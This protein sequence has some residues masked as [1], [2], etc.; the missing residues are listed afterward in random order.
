MPAVSVV[1]AH[2]A[3]S[4]YQPGAGVVGLDAVTS[5]FAQRGEQGGH[6]SS[7]G[8]WSGWW[9]GGCGGR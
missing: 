7:A 3:L 6:L 2:P 4:R 1:G 9:C 8:C 5:Q